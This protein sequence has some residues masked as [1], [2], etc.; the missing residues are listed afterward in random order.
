M[1]GNKLIIY[2]S[3]TITVKAHVVIQFANTEDLKLN[4]CQ[5]KI[6]R[7][8]TFVTASAKHCPT[9]FQ[10]L[11]FGAMDDTKYNCFISCK[12]NFF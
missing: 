12:K 5:D 7:Q 3:I 10:S 8:F 11:N 2:V 9:L 1:Q 4:L 6:R